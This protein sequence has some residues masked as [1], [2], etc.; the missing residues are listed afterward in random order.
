M[1]KSEA[2]MWAQK[3][4]VRERSAFFFWAFLITFNYFI[5]FSFDYV[6]ENFFYRIRYTQI[7]YIKNLR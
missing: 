3:C 2:Q 4:P 1:R 5:L 7:S 6:C